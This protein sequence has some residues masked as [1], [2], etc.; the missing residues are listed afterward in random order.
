M[1]LTQNIID[2]FKTGR[3][4]SFY[5]EA[6]PAL[7]TYAVRILSDGYAFLAEDCVQDCI[8]RSYQERDKITD[9]HS[10]RSFLY[11]SVHNA[12][13]SILRRQK[14]HE[15]YLGQAQIVM[16]SPSFIEQETL[17]LLYAAIERLPDT[18]RAVFELSFEQGLSNQEI[19]DQLGLS[20]SGLKKRKAKMIDALRH[21]LPKDVFVLL[22][23]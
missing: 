19:A 1:L 16:D 9:P 11:T 6:Y 7:L 23:L 14:V 12:A 20:L 17:D 4:D 18:Q 21:S 2:D 5:R 3:L 10:W 8:F 15:T 13:V 22:M